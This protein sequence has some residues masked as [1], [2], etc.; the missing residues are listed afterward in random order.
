MSKEYKE[1]KLKLNGKQNFSIPVSVTK[2]GRLLDGEVDVSLNGVL[3]FSHREGDNEK[4]YMEDVEVYPVI[5]STDRFKI[6][7]G[8]FFITLLG[9]SEDVFEDFEKIEDRLSYVSDNELI[10]DIFILSDEILNENREPV[11]IKIVTKQ[12]RVPY[13]ISVEILVFT[14]D[15]E[16][17]FKTV[18]RGISPISQIRN[19]VSYLFNKI[20]KQPK[21]NIPIKCYNNED[22]IP[23]IKFILKDNNSSKEDIQKK[24]NRLKN[25]TPFGLSLMYDS[26]I[27]FSKNLSSNDVDDIRKLIYMFIDNESN[28]STYSVRDAINTINNID[29]DKKVPVLIGNIN[30]SGSSALSVRANESDTWHINKLSYLTGGQAVSVVDEDHKEEVIGIFYNEM[31]GAFGSGNYE[32]IVD[33]EEECSINNVVAFFDIPLDSSNAYWNIEYSKDGYNYFL[34]K[35]NLQ[36]DDQIDTNVYARYLRFKITLIM[37]FNEDE[38]ASYVESPALTGIRILYNKFKILY[39]YLKTEESKKYS[40]YHIPLAVDS[41]KKDEDIIEAGVSLSDSSNW[42]DFY[43]KASPS[44]NNDGKFVIPIRYS[45]DINEFEQEPLSKID[46]FTLRTKYGRW[47]PYDHIVLY[48]ENDDIINY[49]RY[50]FSS[51]KGLIFLNYSLSDDYKDGDYKIGIIRSDKYK[52]GLKVINLD[53]ENSLEL[54][55]IGYMYS[56]DRDLL[57]PI[58]KEA[59]IARNVRIEDDFIDRFSKVKL[60]YEYYDSSFEKEDI[61]KRRIRWYINGIHITNLDNIIE[62]NDIYN[63]HDPLYEFYGLKYPREEDILTQTHEDF[64]KKQDISILNVGDVIHFEIQ[65]SDGFLYSDIV[66]SNT[67]RVV[68]SAPVAARI[69]IRG[70]EIGTGNILDRVTASTDAVF[71][72]SIENQI[73]AEGNIDDTEIIWYVND[74]LF[75]RGFY[76]D[77]PKEDETPITEI[78]INDTGID[79]VDYALRQGNVISAQIIPRSDGITGRTLFVDEV[80]VENS[81]PRILSYGFDGV[82]LEGNNLNLVWVFEDF[83]ITQ[84]LLGG[85]FQTDKTTVKW[86]RKNQGSDSFEL[87]YT[88][89]DHSELRDGEHFVISHYQNNIMTQFGSNQS[90]SVISGSK[91]RSGQTWYAELTPHDG[92]EYGEKV[93]TEQVI[94][95]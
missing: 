13:Y 73:Y 7:N 50:N 74:R 90:R 82:A 26:L 80:V 54:Y 14:E 8:R 53:I 66:K 28:V 35:N 75:K 77:K 17:Y 72:P 40:P 5:F 29:G 95:S 69:E 55:G 44:V 4:E 81:L 70:R 46:R 27:S 21:S 89:N 59:P 93:T 78:R 65:V 51:R 49:D 9:R 87:V 85:E 56:S 6:Y 86:Y 32:F 79:T 68:G 71:H 2:N 1:I 83:E 33:L 94:I 62:W 91:I 60:Y 52:V 15:G 57:P 25:S 92:I 39:I 84:G 36:Y 16:V 88:Y 34:I 43:S 19:D 24:I 41:N 63:I 22:W 47:S 76:V 31:T 48:D 20:E 58:S 10:G 12:E 30:T 3:K 67:V 11:S 37:G 18:D 23:S 45:K 42:L 38:Y 64:I 61:S